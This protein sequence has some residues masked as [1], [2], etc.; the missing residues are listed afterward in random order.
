MNGKVIS[1]ALVL[2]LGAC[3]TSTQSDFSCSAPTGL[4]CVSMSQAD[5]HVSGQDHS[6]HNHNTVENAQNYGAALNAIIKGDPVVGA[7]RA[8]AWTGPERSLEQVW[9]VWFPSFVDPTGNYHA[10]SEIYIAI[11]TD[12]WIE[13]EAEK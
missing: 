8:R 12:T 1:L 9:R 4:G 2:P 5:G 7:N 6:G 11:P 3:A 10:D 13:T